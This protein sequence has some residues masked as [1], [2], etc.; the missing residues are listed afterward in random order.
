[1]WSASFAPK[2]RTTHEFSKKLPA[3][4][5]TDS[6][7]S[8]AIHT[9]LPTT[10]KTQGCGSRKRALRVRTLRGSWQIRRLVQ[11]ARGIYRRT[12]GVTIWRAPCVDMSSVGSVWVIGLPMVAPRVATT[13]A[14][15]MKTRRGTI[16]GSQTRR[17]RGRMPKTT[18]SGTSGTSNDSIT[19]IGHQD[20]A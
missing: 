11:A 16:R 8:V 12:R 18:W 3:T 14:T 10:V 4:A 17:S 6:A 1:M 19:M 15:S 7:S 20:C 13:S 9:T 2:D 5:V